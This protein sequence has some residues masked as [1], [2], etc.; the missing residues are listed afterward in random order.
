MATSL[1]DAMIC[2]GKFS[3]RSSL[4]RKDRLKK[5]MAS[6][7]KRTRPLKRT[8]KNTVLFVG[9]GLSGGDSLIF[10]FFRSF[11]SCFFSYSVISHLFFTKMQKIKQI[12]KMGY[13]EY[14]YGKDND[15]IVNHKKYTY[16][17][18]K[19]I[20]KRVLNRFK[21]S[22]ILRPYFFILQ[23]LLCFLWLFTLP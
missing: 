8:R 15:S 21:D 5:K 12:E 6:M 16:D 10:C 20:K 17:K 14:R 9:L 19:K 13:F 11:F 22:P 4:W 3:I 7:N 23:F 1:L 2:T 18:G